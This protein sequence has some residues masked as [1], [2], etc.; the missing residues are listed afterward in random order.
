MSLKREYKS[1]NSRISGS[2]GPGGIA[3]VCCNAYGM[4][5]RKMKA[6]TRRM[7]RRVNKQALREET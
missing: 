2:G 4:H 5:P 7:L 3:C 1:V 6:L